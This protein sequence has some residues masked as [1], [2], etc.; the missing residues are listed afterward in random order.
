M[1]VKRRTESD[2][3]R[4]CLAALEARGVFCWRQ[5]TQPTYDPKLGRYRAFRGL[6]G[7]PDIV[8]VVTLKSPGGGL[9]PG[10]FLGVECKCGKGRESPEQ[11]SFR[12]RLVG[13]GGIYVIARDAS[14][15]LAELA[16]YGV[17]FASGSSKLI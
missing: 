16:G 13:G 14:E 12:D 1:S 6:R 11:E 8:G 2:V 9:T 3:L 17:V 5:N 10:V 15:L 4:E 7:V